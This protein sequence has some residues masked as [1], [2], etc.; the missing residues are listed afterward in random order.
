MC[1]R[2]PRS[3]RTDTRFPYTTLFRSRLRMDSCFDFGL[4]A[5]HAF[6]R[7]C[8]RAARRRADILRREKLVRDG[9]APCAPRDPG[10]GSEIETDH[11]RPAGDGE[12]DHWWRA[13]SAA[14]DYD[15][16]A[17]AHQGLPAV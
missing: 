2:P 17:S 5:S 4:A 12:S 10:T 7:A 16:W 14:D 9:S 3:T 6:H 15:G 11:P 13:D 1:R 8:F